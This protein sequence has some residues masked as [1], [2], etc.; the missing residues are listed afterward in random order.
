VVN[1]YANV[2]ESN[3]EVVLLNTFGVA[4]YDALLGVLID[5]SSG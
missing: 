4:R 2:P 1:W 5:T 3:L